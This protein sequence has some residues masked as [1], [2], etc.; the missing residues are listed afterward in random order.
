MATKVQIIGGAFQDGLA[1]ALAGGWLTFELSQDAVANSG[2]PD[3]AQLVSGYK[4]Q[5]NLD[6][7]GNV[8]SSPEAF[9]WPNN[10][11]A[12]SGTFYS[13]SAYSKVGQLVWGPNP[14]S[15]TD[16]DPFDIGTWVPGR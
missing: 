2:T 7:T 6:S 9:I 8:P 14:Q 10:V 4:V 11:L 15:V 3:V 1:N 5:I 13:V 12:P 16:D